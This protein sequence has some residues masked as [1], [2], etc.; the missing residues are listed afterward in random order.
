MAPR[1]FPP[2]L[3]A[4]ATLLTACRVSDGAGDIPGTQVPGQSQPHQLCATA[5]RPGVAFG[6]KSCSLEESQHIYHL[7]RDILAQ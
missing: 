4:G 7:G 2:P 5:V 6:E 1:Y 3:P